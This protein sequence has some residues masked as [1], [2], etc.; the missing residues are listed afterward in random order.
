MAFYQSAGTTLGAARLQADRQQAQQKQMFDV[1]AQGIAQKEWAQ[2]MDLEER[3]LAYEQ[4]KPKAF[5]PLKLLGQAT[6]DKVRERGGSHNQALGAAADVTKG[7]Q[8]GVDVYGNPK[9][10]ST[11][12]ERYGKATGNVY[13]AFAPREEIVSEPI[14]KEVISQDGAPMNIPTK[15][16]SGA[17][18]EAQRIVGSTPKSLL[19]SQGGFVDVEVAREKGQ[20]AAD[21]KRSEE[22][23]AALLGVEMKVQ[24]A[25]NVNQLLYD[26]HEDTDWTTVGLADW[27]KGIPM[28]PAHNFAAKLKVVES[29]A[30]LSKLIEVKEQGGTFGALQ[31][32]ELELLI[33]SRAALLQST[34]PTQFKDELIR[35]Q[36]E[37]NRILPKLWK[38]YE[39]KHGKLPEGVLDGLGDNM[40]PD[41]NARCKEWLEMKQARSAE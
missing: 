36:R 32:K 31:E 26:L 41:K 20:D 33:S 29:D 13:E 39:A 10:G 23:P 28:M 19:K 16:P 30:G 14:G 40:I 7:A 35:Y 9:M 24:E 2:K 25:K 37:R 8:M 3:K 34:S 38:A 27:T 15:R 18:V 12:S 17:L 22:K 11:P 6:Y 4:A 5:D 21:L 1:L